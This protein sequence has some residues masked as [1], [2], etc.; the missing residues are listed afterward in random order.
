MFALGSG[1]RQLPLPPPSWTHLPYWRHGHDFEVLASKNA[2]DT[3]FPD[4]GRRRR[5]AQTQTAL[6]QPS[7]S[8]PARSRPARPP[9]YTLRSPGGRPPLPRLPESLSAS[10]SC[11]ER[12]T[13]CVLRPAPRVLRPASCVLRPAPSYVQLLFF[14]KKENFIADLRRK[15]VCRSS[16]ALVETHSFCIPFPFSGGIGKRSSSGCDRKVP[17]YTEFLQKYN[18][19]TEYLGRCTR[20]PLRPQLPQ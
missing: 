13:S 16:V 15:Y 4:D 6:A 3:K 10:E 1:N 8:R 14:S 9:E 2:E 12:P 20:L 7:P 11:A 17:E 19:D 18:L 5:H